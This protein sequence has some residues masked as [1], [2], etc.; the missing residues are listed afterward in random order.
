ML[1]ELPVDVFPVVSL[2]S[3][4]REKERARKKERG[5]GREKERCDD[6]T[7][8]GKLSPRI[9][10]AQSMAALGERLTTTRNGS[11][12]QVMWPH[13]QLHFEPLSL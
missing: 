12:F 10:K 3:I 8:R 4:L 2:W 6:E 5:G 11:F 1:F 13:K 9:G 7:V